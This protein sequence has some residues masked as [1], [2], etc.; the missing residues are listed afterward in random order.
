MPKRRSRFVRFALQTSA[1]TSIGAALAACGEQSPTPAESSNNAGAVGVAGNGVTAG[2]GTAGQAS[3][4]AGSG[5]ATAGTSGS[6]AGNGGGIGGPGPTI[7][8]GMLF[9]GSGYAILAGAPGNV[10]LAFGLE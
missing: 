5:N 10:L 4:S 7:V 2:A 6:V 3:G 9:T 1:L 8:G